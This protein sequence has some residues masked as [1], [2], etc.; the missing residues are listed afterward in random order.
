MAKKKTTK[1]SA[2]K[3]I[4]KAQGMKKG[5][6]KT[7][8]KKIV[9]K[10]AGTAKVESILLDSMKALRENPEQYQELRKNLAGAK[11]DQ[12]RVKQLLR[13]ATS[14]RELAALIPAGKSGQELMAATTTV[15]VTTVLIL[16]S[17][18]E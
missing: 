7:A 12:D 16:V 4:A 13:Y 9:K 8:K 2:K 1:T 6:K 17:T 3:T 18:A 10:P 5:A 14:E 15:T 11:N